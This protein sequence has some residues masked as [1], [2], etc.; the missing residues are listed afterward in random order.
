MKVE[1]QN[2]TRAFSST[3][4][5]RAWIPFMRVECSLLNHFPKGPTSSYH[6]IGWEVPTHEFWRDTYIQIIAE[7]MRKPES[8]VDVV[9]VWP[10]WSPLPGLSP[11]HLHQHLWVLAANGSQ[12]HP[13]LA[14]CPWPT[15]AIL[16]GNAQEFKPHY[17]N[18][19]AAHSQRLINTGSKAQPH[20]LQ[21]E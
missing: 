8:G 19:G 12:L 14:N 4:F 11:I 17:P 18:S 21:L 15:E 6:H 7:V 16:P 20:C 1:G 10:Q 13:S 2:S 3:S 9:G 5:I